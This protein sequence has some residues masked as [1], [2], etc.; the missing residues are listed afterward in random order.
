MKKKSCLHKLDPFLDENGILRV[1]GRIKLS[2]LS[3]KLKYPI[4]LPKKGQATELILCPYHQLVEH[5]GRVIGQNE[6]R[7][8]GYWIIGGSSAVS[9]H[10]SKCVSC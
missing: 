3:Y 9:N 5:Q 4:F 7:Q 10:I 6:V 2:S 8:A 1:G